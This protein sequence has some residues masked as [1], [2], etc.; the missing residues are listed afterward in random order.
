MSPCD[1]RK[2]ANRRAPPGK[3]IAWIPSIA[4]RLET[5]RAR[6]EQQQLADEPLAEADDFANDF[7][8]GERA[9]DAGKRAVGLRGPEI[10]LRW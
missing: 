7:E 3:R 4:Q 9:G 6:V 2:I 1:R 10:M 5:H 8:R